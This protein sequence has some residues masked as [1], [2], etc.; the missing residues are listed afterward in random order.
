MVG[1]SII[2]FGFFGFST[3]FSFLATFITFSTEEENSSLLFE[4]VGWS[5]FFKEKNKTD[6][7]AQK[8]FNHFESNGWLVGG[9]A[10]MKNWHAA[11]RNWILNTDKFQNGMQQ[12][13]PGDI[14]VNQNKDYS[15]P[16]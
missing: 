6:L 13:K 12:K 3:G 2:G 15:V 16:L 1:N 10:K 9:K 11:A 4:I 7:E 8:F 14:A 5:I